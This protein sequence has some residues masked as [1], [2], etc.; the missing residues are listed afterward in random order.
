VWNNT[1]DKVILQRAEGSLKYTSFLQRSRQQEVLLKGIQTALPDPP[2]TATSIK[3][4]ATLMM[5]SNKIFYS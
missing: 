1:G 3:H 4:A 5:S 2:V